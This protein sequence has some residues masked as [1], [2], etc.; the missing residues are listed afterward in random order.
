MEALESEPGGKYLPVQTRR[1][2]AQPTAAS[3]WTSRMKPKAPYL[4]TSAAFT[5]L[6]FVTKLSF[7]LLFPLSYV[8]LLTTAGPFFTLCLPDSSILTKK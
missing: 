6:P 2:S 7:T 8:G 3:G 4:S 5:H 1:L